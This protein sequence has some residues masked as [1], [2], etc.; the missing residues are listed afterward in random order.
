MRLSKRPSEHGAPSTAS[1]A[2][3]R[4]LAIAVGSITC[5]LAIA[6]CGSSGSA[7]TNASSSSSQGLK[8][9][10]CMRAHGVSNFPDPSTGSNGI[11]IQVGPG[12]GINPQSPA[13]QSAQKACSK[14]LPGG[15]PSAHPSAQA[16]A[17]L[18]RISQCMRAH[19]I[20]GFPDPSTGP[21]PSNPA[22]YSAVI[23]RGGAFLA[24][25]NTIDPRSPA[26]KQAAGACK[27]PPGR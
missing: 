2:A 25:P 24:I 13:F 9:S 7:T 11:K 16:K 23:G 21:P 14:L 12:S 20:S 4:W 10:Q 8:F 17:D 1:A 26:F 27:F 18:L 6:A 15:G 22:A 3:G 19:G 5:G